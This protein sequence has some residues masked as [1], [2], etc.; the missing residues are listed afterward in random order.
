MAANVPAAVPFALNPGA[1]NPG[2][3]IDYNDV[4]NR[5]TYHGS[6]KA[7]EHPYDLHDINLVHFISQIKTRSNDAG[8]AP[9]FNVP[10]DAAN[11]PNGD[12]L[13]LLDH[14]GQLSLQQVR[15]FAQTFVGTETRLAQIDAQVSQCLRKSLTKQASNTMNLESD[16]FKIGLTEVGILFLKMAQ[17][18]TRADTQF[19]VDNIRQKLRHLAIIMVEKG[20]DI[21]RFNEEVRAQVH[22]LDAR[23]EHLE[24]GFYTDLI[25]GYLACT[26]VAFRTYMQYLRDRHDERPLG[27]YDVVQDADGLM[28]LA[29]NKYDQ[30]KELKLW[31]PSIPKTE[32]ELIA[33]PAAAKKTK[34]FV[35]PAWKIAAPTDGQS[36]VKTQNGKT[37]HWCHHHKEWTIHKPSECYKAA[38]ANDNTSSTDGT[39][40]Q[41]R[42]SQ[43]LA[44]V[45]DQES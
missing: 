37:Y 40:P 6:T 30:L 23:G 33:M 21:N 16:K 39:S 20:F 18:K 44:S 28:R 15:A 4:S 22:D 29:A 17:Q 42:I 3:V 5:K 19:T 24:N 27:D 43:A 11:D 26:D 14:Y 32:E 41:L 31:S 10:V 35:K 7:L 1:V 8:W 2:D 13:D 45:L 9:I 36:K 12:A 25:N 38:T 34:Q